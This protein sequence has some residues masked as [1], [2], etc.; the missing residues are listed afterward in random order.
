M[1]EKDAETAYEKRR[2]YIL[3]HLK[4]IRKGGGRNSKSNK[5]VN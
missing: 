1:S 5:E 4:C 2:K 3:N